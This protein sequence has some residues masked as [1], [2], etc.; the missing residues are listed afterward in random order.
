MPVR[1]ISLLGPA[2]GKYNERAGHRRVAPTAWLP[3]AGIAMTPGPP[4]SRPRALALHFLHVGPPPGVDDG[5]RCLTQAVERRVPAPSRRPWGATVIWVASTWA[6]EGIPSGAP[7]SAT[8]GMALGAGSTSVLTCTVM[9]APAWRGPRMIPY[10]TH[11][12]GMGR[13]APCALRRPEPDDLLS[14]NEWRPRVEADEVYR[15]DAGRAGGGACRAASSRPR[16][17]S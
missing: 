2:T 17:R 1:A 12:G 13:R 11:L 10:P 8:S 7:S 6:V 4:P 16:Q 3:P 15:S 5:C 9:G 14:R